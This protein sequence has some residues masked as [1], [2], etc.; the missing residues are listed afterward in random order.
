MYSL[1]FVGE[2][3]K[4]KILEGI[5]SKLKL[6]PSSYQ[7]IFLTTTPP[8]KEKLSNI[9]SNINY[10]TL[11]FDQ[12]ATNDEMFE[13]FIQ[14]DGLNGLNGLSTVILF[15]ES[16]SEINFADVN[17]MIE[18]NK[19]GANLV[20]SKQDKG[21]NIV[22]KASEYLR[23]IFS[24]IFLGVRI[25]NS[26]ADIVLL[27]ELLV[28]TMKEVRGKSSL[29]TKTNAWSGIEPQ[30]VSINPQPK[31]KNKNLP[32]SQYIPIMVMGFILFLMII[33][34]IV[35]AVLNVS[36]PFLGWFGYIVGELAILGIL[37]HYITKLMFRLRFGDVS[38]VKDVEIIKEINNFD[39]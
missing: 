21:D 5:S 3:N 26:E 27:D 18:K 15:K 7:V 39:E 29:L 33:G 31:L 22:R 20:V 17:R 2:R 24:K 1:V 30:Y 10:K 37:L 32:F 36:L 23:R 6:I 35:F 16:A 12:G 13:A 34:N 38:F 9:Y 14:A 25:F 19:N 4:K 8:G 11:L 28:S